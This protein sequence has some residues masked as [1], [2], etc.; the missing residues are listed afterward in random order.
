MLQG[1]TVAIYGNYTVYLNNGIYTINNS[2]EK[3]TS[4]AEAT[5]QAAKLD[6]AETKAKQ[7]QH[8]SH[9]RDALK[10][11]TEMSQEFG[12]YKELE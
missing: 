6:Q 12:G 4:I 3:Y 11:L 1:K 9:T 8:K 7:E 5:K 2:K 10:K